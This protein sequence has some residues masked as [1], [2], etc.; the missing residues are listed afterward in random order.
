MNKTF[1]V[2]IFTIAYIYCRLLFPE[3]CEEGNETLR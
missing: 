2:L 3:K 1:M